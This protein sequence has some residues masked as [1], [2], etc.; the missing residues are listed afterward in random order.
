MISRFN[1]RELV[2][3]YDISVQSRIRNVLDNNHIPYMIKII[4]RNAASSISSRNRTRM[5]LFGEKI[6]IEK[7]YI[8]LVNK[9]DLEMAQL[10]IKKI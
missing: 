7:E 2:S 5:G 9:S 10:L 8:I 3:T 4:D 1:R 6:N